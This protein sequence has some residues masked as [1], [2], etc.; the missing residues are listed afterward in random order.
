MTGRVVPRNRVLVTQLIIQVSEWELIVQDAV[1]VPKKSWQIVLY[2]QLLAQIGSRSDIGL[3][4]LS[5]VVYLHF[6]PCGIRL[7]WIRVLDYWA[8]YEIVGRQVHDLGSL[9]PDRTYASNLMEA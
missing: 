7:Y 4:F 9:K 2:L 6:L 8:G 5:P 1:H 3:A